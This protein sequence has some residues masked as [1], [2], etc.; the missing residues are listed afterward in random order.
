MEAGEA[1]YLQVVICKQADKGLA[2]VIDVDDV[3]S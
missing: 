1:D 2:I 3:D